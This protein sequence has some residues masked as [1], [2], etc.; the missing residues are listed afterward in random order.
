MQPCADSDEV[1]LGPRT[2]QRGAE[3]SIRLENSV[4]SSSAH[5]ILCS[6]VAGEVRNEKDTCG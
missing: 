4:T 5:L 1:S 3:G 2:E 6:I